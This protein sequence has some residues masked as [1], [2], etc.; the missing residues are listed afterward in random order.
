[1]LAENGV[2]VGS[3]S[4]ADKEN[5]AAALYRTALGGDPL[6]RREA[7]RRLLPLLS[8]IPG[9]DLLERISAALPAPWGRTLTFLA[10]RAGA[11]DADKEERAAIETVFFTEPVDD[12]Y[13][14]VL[15]RAGGAS[16]PLF[17]EARAAA[18]AGRLLVARQDFAGALR[19]FRTAL[20]TEGGLFLRYPELLTD[21]GRSLQ[22]GDRGGAELFLKWEE[23]I[24]EVGG[25]PSLPAET[26]Y[27][28]LY[29]AGRIERQRGRRKASTALF[30]RAVEL[31]PDGVQADACIWYILN[32]AL[33]DTIDR[34]NK[35]NTTDKTDAADAIAEMTALLGIWIPRWHN[36]A[37]F[38]DILDTFARRLVARGNWQAMLEVYH[39]L[40]P[41]AA[42]AQYAYILG[43][44]AG[45][46]YPGGTAPKNPPRPEMF[47]QAVINEEKASPYYRGLA[48]VRLGTALPS[49]QAASPSG[50][51]KK[52]GFPHPEPMA[53]LLGFFEHGAAAYAA[54]YIAKY[55]EELSSGEMR[56]LAGAL[57]EAGVWDE[58]L[59]LIA[60][61]SGRDDYEPD[62]ADLELSYP[63][64]FL[65]PIE[66]CAKEFGIS[67]WLLFGLIRTESAFRADIASRAGAVGL[68]QLM[69]DT[70][71]DMAGRLARQGGPDYRRDAGVDLAD[72][73][74]NIHLGAYYLRYLLDR[75]E[76]P[77]MALLAYNGGMGRV[78]R[79][80]AQAREL[81]AD[82]FV[83]T[84]E[85]SE[86]REYA[87]RVAAAAALYGFLYYGLTVD[88]VIADIVK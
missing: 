43:Q 80:R 61:Y 86:T 51:A 63:R 76:S 50:P 48:A 25:D 11:R 33:Q 24:R 62:R 81:S 45:Q 41:E 5:D 32:M 30:G 7:A 39:L 57:Q 26:R 88:I 19:R 28:L 46:G 64:P 55:R 58:S 53:F 79:W 78:R 18:V 8:E 34:I 12:L 54:P 35:T 36:P 38:D 42:R 68:T 85:F 66:S 15:E 1:L 60:W 73:R 10:G 14:W 83:E 29:F 22:F 59:R 49:P 47:F 65:E 31:A 69:P 40:G 2:V 84:V 9:S 16:G 4:P 74:I 3:G 71:L 82:L 23:D 13:R 21:L 44:A 72:P 27:R 75:T 6:V 17:T 56:A 87:R 70:A 52:A 37:V 77:L 20:E 67:P